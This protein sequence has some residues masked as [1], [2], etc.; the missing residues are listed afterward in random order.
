MD[1]LKAKISDKESTYQ[2]LIRRELSI[3]VIGIGYVGYPLVEAL[4]KKFNVIA[5]DNDSQKISD[6]KMENTFFTTREK[7]LAKATVYIITVP[8][9]INEDKSPNLFCIKEATKAIGRNM[10]KGSVIIYESTVAPGTTER[11]CKELLETTSK[12]AFEKDFS[13]GYSPERISPGTDDATLKEINKIVSASDKKTLRLI[14]QLY[15]EILNSKIVEVSSI[16][17]AETSK[18]VENIQ[19]D[20]NIAL[21]NE[22][23]KNFYDTDID[24]REVLAAAATKWNFMEVKPG[25][26]GGHCIGVDPYY[27]IDYSKK[28][29]MNIK[30]I[31]LSR[32]INESEITFILELI[33]DYSK[34]NNYQNCSIGVFGIAYKENI[35]DIRNSKM[36]D[37]C[38]LLMENKKMEL[39]IIDFEVP[40]G[41]CSEKIE[42]C[43]VSNISNKSFDIV[44]I[45]NSHGSFDTLRH[46]WSKITHSNSKIIDLTGK[47]ETWFSSDVEYRHL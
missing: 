38:N 26:V 25:L 8:T 3:A 42:K 1:S 30:L 36:L 23:S 18:I 43:R 39:S 15:R 12:L 19:R 45:G 9:P 5:Y 17:V 10:K 33:N 29:K 47:Y 41:I 28:E 20:V 46:H 7:D 24:F 22:L 34:K 40:H 21:M 4:S 13:L 37:L 14:S 11:V 35:G 31:E 27:F 16:K 32:K 6:L 44:L 2:R